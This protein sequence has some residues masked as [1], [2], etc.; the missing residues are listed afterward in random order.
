[1]PD[2]EIEVADAPEPDSPVEEQTDASPEAAA[3]E[4]DAQAEDIETDTGDESDDEESEEEAPASG[5]SPALQKLLSKYGGDEDALV[6]AYFE[7]ANS[8]SRLAKEFEELKDYLLN[9]EVEQEDPEKVIA[10]DPTVERLNSRLNTLNKDMQEIQQEQMQMIGEY[11]QLENE[12]K[13]LE[14][15]LKTAEDYDKVSLKQEVSL[16]KAEMRQIKT[17]VMKGRRDLA[18][19]ERDIEDAQEFVEEARTEVLGKREQARKAKLKSAQVARLT[20]EEFNVAMRSEAKDFGIDPSSK[21]FQI[22]NT[23]IKNQIASH[24]NQMPKDAPGIDVQKAVKHLMK[25][26]AEGMGV[27]PKFQKISEN[28]KPRTPITS[29]PKPPPLPDGIKEPK[30]PKGIKQFDNKG[31]W[32]KE[33]IDARADKLLGLK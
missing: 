22:I 21:Q 1:M 30:M 10:E 9:K 23:S 16:K 8:S 12:T 14:I 17:N 26:F 2:P 20:K 19:A 33:F 29:G 11:G 31:N 6:N 13:A 32:T 18:K 27:K 28:K 25:E 5:R 4:E 7:Q 3:E 15:Q 24:L